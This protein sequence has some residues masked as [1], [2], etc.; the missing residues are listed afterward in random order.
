MHECVVCEETVTQPVCPNCLEKHIAQKLYETKPKM[1]SDLKRKT[2]EIYFEG[3]DV[4][5]VL[6]HTPISICSHCYSEH[7]KNWL[8]NLNEFGEEELN[9]FFNFL[10]LYFGLNQIEALKS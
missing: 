8:Q 7:I 9:S 1:V 10:N 5:C 3:G 6:C 2:E 4:T